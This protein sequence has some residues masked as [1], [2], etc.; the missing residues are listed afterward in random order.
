[1]VF[2]LLFYCVTVQAMNLL[3]R[4]TVL[5]QSACVFALGY[6][7]K[8]SMAALLQ[9]ATCLMRG[10]VGDYCSESVIEVSSVLTGNYLQN[11]DNWAGLFKAR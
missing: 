1:M 2:E 10:A 7:L 9:H 6:F 8:V 4:N 3:N 11:L 5:N